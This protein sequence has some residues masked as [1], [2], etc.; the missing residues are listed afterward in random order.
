MEEKVIGFIK[1]KDRPRQ[2]NAPKLR[3]KVICSKCK[4]LIQHGQWHFKSH[5]ICTICKNAWVLQLELELLEMERDHFHEKL[6]QRGGIK[7]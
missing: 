6:Q 2:I 5:G 3:K 1:G 4:Y 7:L